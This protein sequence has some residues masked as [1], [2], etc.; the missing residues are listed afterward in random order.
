METS[1]DLTVSMIQDLQDE[2]DR[3]P[4]S[5]VGSDPLSFPTYAAG[6]NLGF[7]ETTENAVATG[8]KTLAEIDAA[9]DAVDG[10]VAASGV[11]VSNDDL[12]VGFLDGKLIAGTN[13]TFTVN[14]PG[15]NETLTIDAAG[16]APPVDSV[17]GRTGAIVA[18]ASDYDASQVD[19]DSGVAGATVADALDNLASASGGNLIDRQVFE[20]SGTWNKP[21]GCNSAYVVVVGG[22]G[23]GGEN[24]GGIGNPGGTGGTSSFGA[25]LQATG[26]AGGIQG[27]QHTI[28]ANYT[29]AEGGT[30]GVGSGGDDNIEGE[31][32]GP[33]WNT[34]TASSATIGGKGGNSTLGGGAKGKVATNNSVGLD[35]GLYGGGGSGC[36]AVNNTSTGPGGGGAGGGTSRRLITSGLGVSETVTVGSGG[37][38]ANGSGSGDGGD[39]ADGV[40]IVWAYT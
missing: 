10:L 14:N 23:G 6:L 9:V 11:K 16:S 31:D 12:S 22:G 36:S 20:T 5:P 38:G 27:R 37:N 7:S 17:F 34:A 19:N 21:A 8:Q 39:G 3:A 33:S 24:G 25:F 13:I 18:E 26:G 30:G 2:V 4:K 35:G 15:G 40:V 1:F 32:G 28:A 29:F